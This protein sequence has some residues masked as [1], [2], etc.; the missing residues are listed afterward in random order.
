MSEGPRRIC[1]SRG[2]EPGPAREVRHQLAQVLDAWA[3]ER[4]RTAPVQSQRTEK[5]QLC[6]LGDINLGDTSAYVVQLTADD[7]EDL[8]RRLLGP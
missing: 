5:A 2:A 4:D 1:G 7:V 3:Q 6:V 8:Q